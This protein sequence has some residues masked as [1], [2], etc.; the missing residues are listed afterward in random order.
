MWNVQ[1]RPQALS[2]NLGVST[3]RQSPPTSLGYSVHQLFSPLVIKTLTLRNRIVSTAHAPN[4]QVEGHPQE[5]Y[6]R[7]HEEKAKGGIGLTMVGG[8]T[9]IAPDSPSVFGQ[10]YAG[11]DSVVPWFQKLTDGVH[12]HGAAIMCQITHMGRRTASDAAHWLP[13]I[14]PSHLRER[15]HRTF[16]KAIETHDISRVVDEFA[17]AAKRCESGGFDGIEILS[18]AHL[19]G[20]FLS[21]LTNQ[22]TD[23]YGGSLENRLRLT[24]EVIDAIRANVT[25]NFILSVRMTGDELNPKGLTLSDCISIAKQ[26]DASG[27]VDLLNLLLGS[28]YDDIGLAQWVPPMGFHSTNPYPITAAIRQAVSIPVMYAGGISDIATADH[29]MANGLVDLVGMT[30]AH[31]A[32]PH[33]VNKLN[34]GEENTIRPCV[35]LGYCVDRVNQGKQAVCGQN[36]AT[37]REYFLPHII[38]QSSAHKNVVVVGGGPAGLEAARVSATRGHQVVLFEASNRLGGQLALAAQSGIRKQVSAV[39]DWLIHEVERLGVDIQLNTFAETSDI[40]RQK[41]DTVIIAT[42]GWPEPPCTEGAELTVSSWDILNRNETATGQILLIDEI[43]DHATAVTACVLAEQGASVTIITPD[44]CLLQEMG[45]TNSAVSLRELARLSV[46]FQCLHELSSVTQEKARYHVKLS[47]VLTGVITDYKAD[48]IV[49]ERGL[50][51]SNSLYYALKA[52]SKNLGQLDNHALTQGM[53]PFIT[54]NTKGEFFLAHIGDC[55][56]GRN[57]H[58]AILEGLRTCANL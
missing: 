20:Q 9:N 4:F 12:T 51:P 32:D 17:M 1:C 24:L 33:L 11:D 3:L 57:M 23:E 28:A 26:L 6:R 48:A 55:V 47:H 43:G 40:L 38:K 25:S 8:S 45:P 54:K 7:Y 53:N 56:A 42:G 15:A 29:A 35:G 10:L 31:I 46:K 50:V 13:A 2:D 21:P 30:R 27:H 22:R 36:A 49:V 14:A 41:P 52:Q 19:L 39:S 16:P 37:G 34:N 18:H 58:A 44:R 5:Q